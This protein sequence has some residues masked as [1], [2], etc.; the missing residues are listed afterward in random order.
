MDQSK[1]FDTA[2][3]IRLRGLYVL[4]RGGG[5]DGLRLTDHLTD[6]GRLAA[7][8]LGSKNYKVVGIKTGFS[9]D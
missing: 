5:K 1:A 6:M 7:R 3:S 2:C 4:L 9:N 8:K